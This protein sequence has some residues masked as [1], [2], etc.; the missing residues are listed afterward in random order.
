MTRP[1]AVIA[2]LVAALLLPAAGCGKSEEDKARATVEDYLEAIS[3]GDGDKAC[4]L[5]SS[6][7]RKR[8]ESSGTRTCPETF[9]SLNQGPGKAV[10]GAFKDAEVKD[11][12]VNGDRAT[13]DIELR[14]LKRKTNLR[15]EDGDWKLDSTGVAG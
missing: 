6:R 15:K 4:D 12:K 2:V 8:I 11:V 1:R 3:K 5:V 9:K 14:G 7:T 10:L 13:A